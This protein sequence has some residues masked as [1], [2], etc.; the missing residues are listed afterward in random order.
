MRA[1]LRD[2]VESAPDANRRTALNALTTPL[3][4]LHGAIDASAMSADPSLHSDGTSISRL[5]A[6]LHTASAA[7]R[8]DLALHG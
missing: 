8:A 2:L 3:A 6:Q 4:E 5:A 1:A 7:A